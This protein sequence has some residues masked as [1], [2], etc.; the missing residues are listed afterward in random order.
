MTNP[1]RTTSIIKPISDHAAILAEMEAWKTKFHDLHAQVA[2]LLQTDTIII[3][4]EGVAR[5]H[6]LS[7]IIMMQAE[8]NYTTIHLS[9][10]DRIL[11]SKTL[12]YWIEKI[13]D[14]A[15]FVRPHRSYLV[16][17]AHIIEHHVSKRILTLTQGH[18]AQV[19]RNYTFTQNFS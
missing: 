14:H 16:N 1:F 10:G 3:K 9:N 12:K 15:T 13:G 8:S 2:Q 18:K 11:T 7:D 6:R 19:A 4:D 17:T 5:Y